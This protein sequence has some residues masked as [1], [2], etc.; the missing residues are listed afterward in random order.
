[1]SEK[2]IHVA[3]E[4]YDKA[5]VAMKKLLTKYGRLDDLLN[6]Y[7]LLLVKLSVVELALG[8]TVAAKVIIEK[9]IEYNPTA[10]VCT[11]FLLFIVCICVHIL[12][13]CNTIAII[14]YCNTIIGIDK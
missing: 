11:D 1:M 13:I 8:N 5:N 3:K 6:D 7:A 14:Q 2:K 12:E 9:S 4:C 10:E